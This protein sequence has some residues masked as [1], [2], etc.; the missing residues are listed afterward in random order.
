M[1]GKDDAREE[2]PAFRP[3]VEPN[4]RAA[5]E[6]DRDDRHGADREAE[7]E[8]RENRRRADRDLREREQGECARVHAPI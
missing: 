7:R 5:C 2:E 4:V 8:A 1:R 6:R 3:R